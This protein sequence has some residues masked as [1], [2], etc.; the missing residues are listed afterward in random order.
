MR[1][2]WDV[3]VTNYEVTSIVIT[4][5]LVIMALAVHHWF[6]DPFISIPAVILLIALGVFDVKLK[7]SRTLK[8][9]EKFIDN[10]LEAAAES[11]LRAIRPPVDHMRACLMFP[12][13]KGNL[14][15]KYA[16]GFEPE[17]LDREIVVPIGTGCCGQTW[18]R[19]KAMYADLSQM[20]QDGAP[21]HWG[22]PDAEV[23]KIREGL[24]SILSVPVRAGL[25]YTVVAILNIDTD[26]HIS[27]TRFSEK[28]IQNISYSFSKALGSLMDEVM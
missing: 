5:A 28:S 4:I 24:Q 10:L 2:L 6:A 25:D 23:D 20:P 8:L 1:K 19:G 21:A 16:Y 9:H 22:L 13:G 26:N 12:D 11:M 14:R 18:Q 3:F 7:K 15:I 17:D 27:E